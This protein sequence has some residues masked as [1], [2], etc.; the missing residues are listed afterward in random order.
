MHAR[1][2]ADI[3]IPVSEIPAAVFA[4]IC[5]ALRIENPARKTAIK[6]L[7]WGAR[8]MPREIAL[9]RFEGDDLVLPRGFYASLLSGA[10]ALKI[11]IEWQ[12]D[13]R[14]Y[15]YMPL[16]TGKEALTPIHLRDYQRPAVEALV[17]YEQGGLSMPTGGGK[18]AC[19]LEAIRCV[20]QPT[21]IL[22]DRASL[23]EQWIAQIKE[24]LG[25]DAGYFGENKQDIR[26]ITV[27]L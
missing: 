11:P 2:S 9:Y 1:L 17:T 10:Q 18:T 4:Q 25:A 27:G 7:L 13:R 21:L 22:V 23:A 16:T 20:D 15:E 3:R 12:D 24:K 19:A 8:E 5:A 14:Y 6:E 26:P